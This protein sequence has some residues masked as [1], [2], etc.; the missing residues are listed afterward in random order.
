[1]A[2]NEPSP[3]G[4]DVVFEF[5]VGVRAGAEAAPAEA[6]PPADTVG[7]D[8]PEAPTQRPPETGSSKLNPVANPTRQ[9]HEGQG[10]CE[11]RPPGLY[12]PPEGERRRGSDIDQAGEQKCGFEMHIH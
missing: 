4:A 8:P 5:L 9:R 7:P 6:A 2:L 10:V 1:M 12:R 3:A 11:L